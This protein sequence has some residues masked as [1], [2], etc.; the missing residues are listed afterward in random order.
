[1]RL[2]VPK[3][4]E[5]VANVQV[6]IRSGAREIDARSDSQGIVRSSTPL[7]RLAIVTLRFGGKDI[8]RMPVPVLGERV[9]CEDKVGAETD[10]ETAQELRREQWESRIVRDLVLVDQRIGELQFELGTSLEAAKKHAA[11]TIALIDAETND[12]RAEEREL[13]RIAPGSTKRGVADLGGLVQRKTRLQ[14]ATLAFDNAIA[15]RDASTQRRK[16]AMALATRAA[17]LE[18]QSK[19]D[20]AIVLYDQALAKSPE[21]TKVR[22]AADALKKGWALHGN[23]HEQAR[24][25]IVS[26]WPRLS[27]DELANDLVRAERALEVCRNVGDKLT[28]RSFRATSEGHLAKILAAIAP[29]RRSVSPDA[30]TQVRTLSQTGEEIRR[31]V[32]T[33]KDER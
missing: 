21:L 2:V 28:P 12:L 16:E 26:T 32:A 24:K 27:V 4:F 9:S 25:F 17:L 23:D 13:D 7:D 3:T 10:E 15:E 19:F 14:A 6:K 11:E 1:M 22:E 20:D 30:Q 8:A 31:L 18:S 5:P 33:I 29:L